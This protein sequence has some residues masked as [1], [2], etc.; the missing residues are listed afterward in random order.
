[1]FVVNKFVMKLIYSIVFCMILSAASA[2]QTYHNRAFGIA[3]DIPA[4]W[5]EGTPKGID[6]N[7]EFSNKE[8]TALLE[9]EGSVYLVNFHKSYVVW[10]DELI[11]KIQ[12]NTVIKPEKTFA[13]FKKEATASADK[14]KKNLSDF[15]YIQRPEEITIS[16]IRSIYFII[17]YTMV[18]NGKEMNIRNHTYAIP[19]QNYLFHISLVDGLSNDCTALFENLI[20]TIKVGL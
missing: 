6:S 16:G 11:P 19:Y 5:I 20:K 7:L 1:M 17:Q 15:E 9:K 14:L 18:I 8:R 10:T 4:G 3:I 13:E 12:I 2:Q